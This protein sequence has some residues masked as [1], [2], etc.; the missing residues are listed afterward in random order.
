LSKF[1]GAAKELTAALVINPYDIDTVAQRI[2]E[3]LYMRREERIERWNTMMNVLRRGSLQSWFN[4]FIAA[5]QTTSI[6]SAP[7]IAIARSVA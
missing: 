4:S 1:A 3:A 7:V 5:M 2:H 6:K